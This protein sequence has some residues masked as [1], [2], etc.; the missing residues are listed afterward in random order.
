MKICWCCILPSWNLAGIFPG[1]E[2]TVWRDFSARQK[3]LYH[4]S[5]FAVVSHISAASNALL[6]GI[7]QL[8]SLTRKNTTFAPYKPLLSHEKS[9]LK[10]QEQYGVHRL[11]LGTSSQ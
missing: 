4:F 3:Q 11:G 7:L 1:Q 10:G 6:A 5:E 8:T 2:G 9:I